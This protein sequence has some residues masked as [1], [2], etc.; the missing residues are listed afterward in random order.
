VGIEDVNLYVF[1]KI[2]LKRPVVHH[3]P[4]NNFI[5]PFSV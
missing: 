2:N 1:V 4:V 5:I 3:G